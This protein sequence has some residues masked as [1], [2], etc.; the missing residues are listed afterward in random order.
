[1]T[2]LTTGDVVSTNITNAATDPYRLVSVHLAYAWSDIGQAI[3]DSL[4]FGLCHSDYSAAEVEECLEAGEAIDIGDKIAQE[5]VNRLVRVIG[6][7]ANASGVTGSGA[8]FNDGKPVRTKLNWKMA[9]GDRLNV[10]VRNGSQVTYL[11][12]SVLNAFGNLWIK[13]SV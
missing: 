12:G 6:V 9:T 3:D 7:I 5:K 13:D 1:M 4:E 2:A 10:F 11:T 8:Q